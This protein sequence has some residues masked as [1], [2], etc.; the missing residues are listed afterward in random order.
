MNEKEILEKDRE[1]KQEIIRA[2][3]KDFQND[4]K[5]YADQI[6]RLAEKQ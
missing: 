3:S 1:I 4:V 5:G 6:R 2:L